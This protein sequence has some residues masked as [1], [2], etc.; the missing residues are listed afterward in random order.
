M[1]FDDLIECHSSYYFFLDLG[2]HQAGFNMEVV[3]RELFS[4][5]EPMQHASEAFVIEV[6]YFKAEIDAARSHKS[7]VDAVDGVCRHDEH[8]AMSGIPD[9][10]G[11]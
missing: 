2:R 9:H 11:H 10:R 6:A 5:E 8:A 1:L 7:W 3:G 4:W